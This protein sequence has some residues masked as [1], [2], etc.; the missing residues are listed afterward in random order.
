[1]PIKD[2]AAPMTVFT[3]DLGLVRQTNKQSVINVIHSDNY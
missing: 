2:T 1:M 3:E